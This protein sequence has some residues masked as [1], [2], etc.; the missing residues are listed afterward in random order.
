MKVVTAPQV[1]YYSQ[2]LEVDRERL[3]KSMII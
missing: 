3:L 1:L 2:S